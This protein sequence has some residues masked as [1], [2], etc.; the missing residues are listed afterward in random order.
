MYMSSTLSRYVDPADQ[1]PWRLGWPCFFLSLVRMEWKKSIDYCINIIARCKRV[2][3][4]ERRC[5]EH[6]QHTNTPV[7][8]K[9]EIQRALLTP[10]SVVSPQAPLSWA[11]P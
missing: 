1:E 9:K 10:P 3:E 6:E 4:T 8:E 7:I 11:S 5:A 2:P